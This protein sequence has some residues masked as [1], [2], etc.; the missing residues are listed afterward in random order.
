[1]E[2]F[3]R[4]LYAGDTMEESEGCNLSGTMLVNKVS[5]NLHVAMG[6]SSIKQDQHIH[7]FDY[8]NSHNFNISHTIHKLSFG[9]SYPGKPRDA[10]DGMVQYLD[11][12]TGTGFMQYFINIVPTTYDGSVSGSS[13]DMIT[14][15]QYSYTMKF[16]SIY[17]TT[18]LPN[19]DAH[20]WTDENEKEQHR[21]RQTKA[22]V[23]P[24]VFFVY[25]ITPYVLSVT[26]RNK[27]P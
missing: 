9:A 6:E 10:L 15:S 17:G 11:E 13:S 21:N 1:M 2:D 27:E 12:N 20:E 5:G 16:R 19:S 4:N 14:S 25:E 7:I 8:R 22:D 26:Y 3:F 23:M 24:S 18:M